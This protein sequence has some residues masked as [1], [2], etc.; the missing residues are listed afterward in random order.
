[1]ELHN[2]LPRQGPGSNKITNI[3]L[4]MIYTKYQNPKILDIGCGPGMQ[5]LCLAEYYQNGRIIAF[6]LYRQFL[7]ELELRAKAKGLDN[8]IELKQGAMSELPYADEEFDIIWSEGAIYIIGFEKG[9]AEWKRFIKPQGFLCVSEL[10]WLTDTRPAELEKYWKEQYDGIATISE[11][12][13]IV[14]KT[15]YKIIGAYVFPKDAWFDEYYNP[16]K[17]KIR[18]YR[19]MENLT[20]EMNTV[21][22]MEEEEINVFERYSD[23][24]GYVF[25]I[26][27]KK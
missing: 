22:D 14:E 7:D 13:R 26:M 24:Y 27:Q 19:E 18:K 12:L 25:Y 9:C 21:L 10:S 6:D 16:I 20:G 17:S 11:N 4:S 1:M 2:G 15:G 3:A 8:R 5:T 23:Y